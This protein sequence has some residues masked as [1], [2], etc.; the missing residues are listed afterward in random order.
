MGAELRIREFTR[1][2]L[3]KVVHIAQGSFAREFEIFG[4]DEHSI[5]EQLKAYRLAKWAQRFSRRKFVKLCVGEADGQAVA[6]A[7]IERRGRIWYLSAVMVDPQH[8]GKGYGKR[9]VASAA[10]AACAFGAERAILHVLENNVPAQ[11]LYRSLGFERFERI[12]HYS[13]NCAPAEEHELP[14]GVCLR[15]ID[16]FDRRALPIID[17]SRSRGA[18]EVY[19]K[20]EPP[21]WQR[22]FLQRL[23]RSG[24]AERH[25]IVTPSGWTGIY[26]F[27]ARQAKGGAG[28]VSIN[29][30][31]Q[32]RGR[33]IERALLSRGSRRA[34]TLG[35]PR[36]IAVVDEQ[37]AALK[38]A[39]EALDFNRLDV[40]E[41][42]FKTCEG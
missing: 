25:A 23:F 10:A 34:S 30:L 32:H 20:S 22:R 11:G 1:H 8:R 39:C 41:G 31:P 15:R 5:A 4:L 38:E 35:S 2:D 3:E 19:G 26:T 17:E 16:F 7:L 12:I 28:V 29:L 9:I 37:N 6:V 24:I 42:M 40:L 36:L 13:R 33:G 21:S 14:D 27:T 18:A